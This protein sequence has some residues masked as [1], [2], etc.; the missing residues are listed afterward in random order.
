M[1]R[2]KVK[3]DFL[4]N[5]QQWVKIFKDILTNN[6]LKEN[7]PKL[8][9]GK[10]N[11]FKYSINYFNNELINFIN[12]YLKYLFNNYIKS[13]NNFLNKGLNNSIRYLTILFFKNLK[14]M[15]FYNNL[16]FVDKKIKE[17]LN[18]E[19]Q[20]N[21]NEFRFKLDKYLYINS[22][23]N[24]FFCELSYIINKNKGDYNVLL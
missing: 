11:D 17:N 3:H 7:Y 1:L 9:N 10:L 13:L 5:Y 15:L 4:E 21:V 12:K 2:K 6:T 14:M 16:N 22:G 20:R 19:I 18:N 8:V 23:Y 24:S